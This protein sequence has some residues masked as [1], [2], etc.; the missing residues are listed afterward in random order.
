V[1]RASGPAGDPGDAS[2]EEPSISAHGRFVAF[3]SIADNLSPQPGDRLLDVAAGWGD[4]GLL[5]APHVQPGGTVLITDG[6]EAMVQA[7]RRRARKLDLPGV[8]GQA[9]SPSPSPRRPDLWFSPGPQDSG[10][11]R[12]I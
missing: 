4:T 8:E 5:A 6:A 12:V 1:S 9:V 7:A 3:Q 11:E 2:S 10:K